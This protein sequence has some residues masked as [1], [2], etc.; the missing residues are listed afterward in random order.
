MVY[1]T[2]GFIAKPKSLCIH[3][4][5]SRWTARLSYYFCP[6]DVGTNLSS[7]IFIFELTNFDIA[8]ELLLKLSSGLII[9]VSDT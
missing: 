4:L 1:P 8:R 6:D 7:K 9:Y 5:I 2:K 3:G